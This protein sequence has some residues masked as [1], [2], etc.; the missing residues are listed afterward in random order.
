MIALLYLYFIREV[1]SLRERSVIGLARENHSTVFIH[2][3]HVN[4]HITR[5]KKVR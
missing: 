2:M 3:L 5:D 4:I 1:L